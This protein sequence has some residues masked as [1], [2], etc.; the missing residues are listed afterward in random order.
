VR[1]RAGAG[2][3]I[4]A[5][6]FDD[7]YEDNFAAAAPILEERGV[8]GTFFATVGPIAER[9]ILWFD[10]AAILWGHAAR[11]PLRRAFAER[12]PDGARALRFPEDLPG[13]IELL[14]RVPDDAR[15]DLLGTLEEAA[16]PLPAEA[17][18]GYRLMTVENLVELARRGHE[19]ASH[20][21]SHPFLTGLDPARLRAELSDSRRT[22]AGW[23]GQDVRGFC[24]PAGD[25]DARVVRE[26]REAGYHYACTTEEGP[27]APGRDPHTLRRNDITSHRVTRT[28][29]EHDP[30]GFRM[31]VSGLRHGMRR[32]F[33]R[34]P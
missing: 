21:L 24:Y 22:L 18:S 17:A 8:R 10:R 2:K 33:G 23:L 9:R 29:L 5:L 12:A 34:V 1:G 26:V 28:A 20:T 4:V 11:E 19:V 7:G 15:A 27:N 32:L 13:W 3:P 14:R 6:T 25:V 31:E 16:A 30:I